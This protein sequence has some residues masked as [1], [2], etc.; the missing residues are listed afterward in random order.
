MPRMTTVL[1]TQAELEAVLS[2]VG[3]RNLIDD[4]RQ[5]TA[6][7]TMVTDVIDMASSDVYQYLGRRYDLDAMAANPWVMWVAAW[8]AAKYAVIRKN[9]Q[10]TSDMREQ[11]AKYE[12]RLKEIESGSANVPDLL[13][14]GDFLPGIVNTTVDK[15]FRDRKIRFQPQL[16]SQHLKPEV[17]T[18]VD[19]DWVAGF[20]R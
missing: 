5:G 10:M 4:K 6:D 7:R 17:M 12:S 20:I 15:R 1:C 19:P 2:A 18:S 13:E 16:S 3:L 9:G 8:F 11:L 14:R